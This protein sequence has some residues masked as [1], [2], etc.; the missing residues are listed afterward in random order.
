[1]ISI[2]NLVRYISKSSF[3]VQVTH[4]AKGRVRW[5]IKGKTVLNVVRG[6]DILVSHGSEGVGCGL[7]C[8]AVWCFTQLLT[9]LHARFQVRRP[10]RG[11]LFSGLLHRTV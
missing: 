3:L 5:Q 2:E 6:S 10:A 8:G 4:L 1:M 11:W 9:R 7:G